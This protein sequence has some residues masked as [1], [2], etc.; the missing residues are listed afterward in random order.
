MIKSYEAQ[1]L[2]LRLSKCN[3]FD[4]LKAFKHVIL[5]A[6]YIAYSKIH[7]SC[8]WSL[9]LIDS[10]D[11]DSLNN[12]DDRSTATRRPHK[13]SGPIIAPST[14]RQKIPPAIAKPVKYG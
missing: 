3:S 6:L 7:L 4:Q 10:S 14:P 12:V 9:R 5:L 2:M 1:A 11:G 8:N 13:S